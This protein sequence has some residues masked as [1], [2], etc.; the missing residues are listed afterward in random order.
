M[1]IFSRILAFFTRRKAPAAQHA[2]APCKRKRTHRKPPGAGIDYVT[3]EGHTKSYSDWSKT[4]GI[5]ETAL[6]WRLQNG[7]PMQKAM[8][9]PMRV[10]VRKK[11]KAG[12]GA[13]AQV[14]TEA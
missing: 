1:S 8:T 7:W 11:R 12:A 13:P 14:T 5:S 10:V 6:R 9:T 2:S 3:Y 4:T